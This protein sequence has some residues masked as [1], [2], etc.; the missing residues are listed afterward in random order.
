VDRLQQYADV[1]ATTDEKPAKAD[2][3]ELETLIFCARN[4]MI[5]LDYEFATAELMHDEEGAEKLDEL[6]SGVSAVLEYFKEQRPPQRHGGPTP[7]RSRE[8]CAGV[9]AAIWRER[10]GKVEPISTYLWKACEAYWRAC[11]R[12]PTPSEDSWEHYLKKWSHL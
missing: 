10:V 12:Q 8:I 5:G 4:L 2:K 3:Q 7:N 6:L 9:C 1:I 11:N